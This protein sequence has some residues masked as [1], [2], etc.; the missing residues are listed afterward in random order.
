MTVR[1]ATKRMTH[2]RATAADYLEDTCGI[3]EHVRTWD[4]AGGWTESY[5]TIATYACR[6]DPTIYY[7]TEQAFGQE[8][9]V[10]NYILSVPYDAVISHDH[11]ILIRGKYYDVVRAHDNHTNRLVKRLL[12]SEVVYEPDAS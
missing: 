9:T 10:V 5:Q 8:T 1:G 11:R 6:L 3:V 12:V 4:A 2:L 7:R